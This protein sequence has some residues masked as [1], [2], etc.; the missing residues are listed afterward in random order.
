MVL[1]RFSWVFYRGMLWKSVEIYQE[2]VR[3]AA[4]KLD[5]RIISL[6]LAHGYGNLGT[7][8][9]SGGPWRSTGTFGTHGEST[10]PWDIVEPWPQSC[11]AAPSGPTCDGS[12]WNYILTAKGKWMP[13]PRSRDAHP[14]LHLGAKPHS[15]SRSPDSPLFPRGSHGSP[16]GLDVQQEHMEGQWGRKDNHGP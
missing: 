15:N 12:V 6:K 13:I 1:R 4:G 14:M 16:W 8:A 5:N 11:C 3:G 10:G 9:D 2:T 7:R